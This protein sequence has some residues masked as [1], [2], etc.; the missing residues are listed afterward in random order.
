MIAMRARTLHWLCR[1]MIPA[2][3][4]ALACQQSVSAQVEL[5][6]RH[7]PNETLYYELKQSLTTTAHIA[8]NPVENVLS[9]QL[10]LGTH[11]NSVSPDGTASVTK[12]IYRI[13]MQASQ[14]GQETPLVYDSNEKTELPGPLR[15]IANSL[16]QLVNQDIHMNISPQGETEDIRLP[17][18]LEKRLSATPAG[19]A[20]NNSLDGVKKMISQGSII[21]PE[22]PLRLNQSWTRELTTELPFG[23]MTSTIEL[24]YAGTTKEG[25]HRINATSKIALAAKEG[26]LF[27]VTMKSADGRGIYLFDAERGC[28][29][30]SALKQ[31]MDLEMSALGQTV[32]Q[33]V[34]TDI[35]MRLVEPTVTR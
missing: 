26:A 34:V 25:L 15:L 13:Q 33:T 9:Q 3:L 14:P 5:R 21:F 6:F 7:T 8:G 31:N 12:R 2:I 17:E 29:Y 4:A 35:T 24:T 32:Q 23:I 1:G 18:E 20:G 28:I 11:V 10:Q 19:I 16:S 30:A 22:G 27:Q